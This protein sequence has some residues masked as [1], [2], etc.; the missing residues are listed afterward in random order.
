MGF[1]LLEVEKC[2]RLGVREKLMIES[3][4]KKGFQQTEQYQD[5]EHTLLKPRW[6]QTQDISP[7]L[8]RSQVNVS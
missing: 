4:T 8:A 6:E 7:C 2:I 5:L 3:T 1:H